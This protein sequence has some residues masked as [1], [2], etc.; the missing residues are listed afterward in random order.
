MIIVKVIKLAW[1]TIFLCKN[2]KTPSLLSVFH[3]VSVCTVETLL[4]ITLSNFDCSDSKVEEL[5][6]SLMRIYMSIYRCDVM[7]ISA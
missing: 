5:S 4:V 7:Q 3:L 6:V 1:E 2:M